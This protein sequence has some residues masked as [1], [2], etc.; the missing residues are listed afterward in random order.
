MFRGPEDFASAVFFSLEMQ[1]GGLKTLMSVMMCDEFFAI[2]SRLTPHP[3]LTPC[4]RSTAR[5]VVREIG[6]SSDYRSGSLN[7]RSALFA[8]NFRR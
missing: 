4:S 6:C 7:S 2:S 8:I 5:V 1:R 3:D